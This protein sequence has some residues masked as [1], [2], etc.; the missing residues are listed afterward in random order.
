MKYLFILAALIALSNA[1]CSVDKNLTFI[2]AGDSRAGKSFLSNILLQRDEFEHS[3]GTLP[4][5][6]DVKFRTVEQ[7][8][9]KCPIFTNEN[10]KKLTINVVDTPSFSNTT[11]EQWMNRIY[12]ISNQLNNLNLCGRII[13]LYVNKATE[14]RYTNV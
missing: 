13:F 10:G 7:Q 4:N 14:N 9:T 5:T 8:G 12:R 11:D 2:L 6:S 1:Q 3:S